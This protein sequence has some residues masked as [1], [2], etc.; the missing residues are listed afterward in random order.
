M[1]AGREGSGYGMLEEVDEAADWGV[2]G[3]GRRMKWRAGPVGVAAGGGRTSGI[4]E[5]E[6]Q[7]TRK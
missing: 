6:I 7:H 5:T 4:F 1:R 3:E 2:T